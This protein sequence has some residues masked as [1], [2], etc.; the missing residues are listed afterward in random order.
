MTRLVRWAW[1]PAA[2]IVVVGVTVFLLFPHGVDEGMPRCGKDRLDEV[3]FD[4]S[5]EAK[6]ESLEKAIEHGIENLTDPMVDLGSSDLR[7][8]RRDASTY[9]VLV[10]HPFAGTPPFEVRVFHRGG[11]Y[12]VKSISCA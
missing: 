2:A 6:G 10:G 12:L 4:Y 11:G 9:S 1:L 3:G 8:E 7:I 5:A